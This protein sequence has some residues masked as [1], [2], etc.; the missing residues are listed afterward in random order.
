MNDE[1]LTKYLSAGHP[2]SVRRLIAF[3]S[4]MILLIGWLGV[5]A[6]LCY[7]A[8][9]FKPVDKGLLFGWGTLGGIIGTL[10]K[11]IFFRKPDPFPSP[12]ALAEERQVKQEEQ[13]EEAKE[14]NEV[15]S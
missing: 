11:Y 9:N 6:V 3:R 14:A 7:Q 2:E 10:A 8:M 5:T 13:A 12:E 15:K 4:S 1:Q